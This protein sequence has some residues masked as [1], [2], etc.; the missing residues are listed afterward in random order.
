MSGKPVR[1]RQVA[2]W[3]VE[4]AI[5]HYLQQGGE[6]VALG[7]IDALE[8]TYG[9]IARQPAAG[10]PRYAHELDLP[11]LRTRRLGRYPYIVFYVDTGAFIDVW[12]VLDGR[13]DIPSAIREDVTSKPPAG[14]PRAAQ[15]DE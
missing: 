10:S 1:P 14:D 3:D 15:D 6:R 2:R 13:R 12:R 9:V 7:F 8:R 5:D 11:G 4:A